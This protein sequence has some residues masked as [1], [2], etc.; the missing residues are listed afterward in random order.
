MCDKV[1][2]QD[3][4]KIVDLMQQKKEKVESMTKLECIVKEP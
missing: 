3:I 2:S 4:E 1:S